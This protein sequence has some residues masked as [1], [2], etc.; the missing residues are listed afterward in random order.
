MGNG[1]VYRFIL[2]KEFTG[3]LSMV[4]S[5]G[6]KIFTVEKEKSEKNMLVPPFQSNT[7]KFTWVGVGVH[8]ICECSC[9]LEIGL[10]RQVVFNISTFTICVFG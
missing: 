9:E 8:Y 7:T 3:K 6:P 1:L 2:I 5:I 10:L 4:V